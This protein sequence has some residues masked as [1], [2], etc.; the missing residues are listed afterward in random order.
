MA[1]PIEQFLTS[2]TRGLFGPGGALDPREVLGAAQP[3]TPNPQQAQPPSGGDFPTGTPVAAAP[4][5][6]VQRYTAEVDRRNN[7]QTGSGSRPVDNGAG[8]RGQSTGLYDRNVAQE[9]IRQA[10]E[11]GKSPQ[12]AAGLAANSMIESGGNPTAYNKSEG[13]FGLFQHRLD[14]LDNMRG[15]ADRLGLDINDVSA[16]VSFGLH[17]MM[18]HERVA[19]DRIMGGGGESASDYARLIDKYWERS[20]G[21]ARDR[22]ANL[23]SNI[24]GDFFSDGAN[25]S[26]QLDDRY[27][28]RGD[29]VNNEILSFGRDIDPMGVQDNMQRANS[30]NPD[31]YTDTGRRPSPME[32]IGEFKLGEFLNQIEAPE[33]MTPADF[34][35]ADPNSF[36]QAA[37]RGETA[38]I[39]ASGLNGPDA[40]A[41]ARQNVQA[42][43][44][45]GP[46]ANPAT[47][48]DIDANPSDFMQAPAPQADLVAANPQSMGEAGQFP[49]GVP[50]SGD[51]QTRGSPPA[52]SSGIRAAV[53]AVTD[54]EDGTG[55]RTLLDRIFQTEG[56]SDE[57]R[58]NRKR[59]LW[60]GLAESLNYLTKGSADMSG[61][62][63]GADQDRR[64]I[65]ERETTER[66]AQGLER[67]ANNMGLGQIAGLA[68]MGD[69]AQSSL[70]SA[71]TAAVSSGGR[72][73]SYN[74]DPDQ[75]E[76]MA[77]MVEA[78][79]PGMA[80][81][82]R[83]GSGKA[84]EDAV[85]Q[86]MKF[87]TPSASGDAEGGPLANSGAMAQ[88]LAALGASP[89][90]VE[91]MR[92]SEN[93]A[94]QKAVLDAAGYGEDDTGQTER[95]AAALADPNVSPEVKAAIREVLELQ[96]GTTGTSLAQE[97][98]SARVTA[99]TEMAAK[100]AAPQ[101]QLR[102]AAA[103]QFQ[104]FANPS[105]TPNAAAE[106]FRPLVQLLGPFVPDGFFDGV[107]GDPELFANRLIDGIS[108]NQLPNL[109]AGVSGQ[110]SNLEGQRLLAIMAQAGDN[111]MQ[112][113]ALSQYVTRQVDRARAVE[114]ARVGYLSGL[115]DDGQIRL[116][117]YQGVMTKAA[118]T[119]PAFREI[120]LND[121]LEEADGL[122]L[123]TMPLSRRGEVIALRLP[124]G[125]IEYRT[126]GEYLEDA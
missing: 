13:A 58:T 18:T 7:P 88:S 50:I 51:T 40:E 24:Y 1:N 72:G 46:D 8:T 60:R 93:A 53:N 119:I 73:S 92:L 77:S 15:Y 85:Q 34:V 6:A 32:Q 9:I 3:T 78:T 33:G 114:E 4:L 55:A 57:Q 65:V 91:S 64:E 69:A 42:S 43:G 74:L 48:D 95:M 102:A 112:G 80:S 83:S 118:E 35:D 121:F 52:P 61:V 124:D 41:G 39:V 122:N 110:L 90:I 17:E 104:I 16:Q 5:T 82:I 49:L 117:D 14:R 38:E 11:S 97:A 10:L 56:L 63:A 125:A 86:A 2:A 81:V 75:R 66:R 22:R 76:T 108:N 120:S 94:G 26:S 12:F 19:Y 103:Q 62:Y 101:D 116:T 28:A 68:Y 113:L 45:S 79:N 89:E 84:L 44:L 37:A 107:V 23:A 25:F 70:T 59:N 106:L 126:F 30:Q 105:Y 98:V 115:G 29:T 99:D 71:M 123:E 87:E 20:D 21:Q 31:Q 36:M 54:D 100:A 27:P 67:I 47:A 96:A 111:R 109:A